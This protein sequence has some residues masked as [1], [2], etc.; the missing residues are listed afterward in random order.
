M[1][2]KLKTHRKK[3]LLFQADKISTEIHRSL[4]LDVDTLHTKYEASTPPSIQ[5]AADTQSRDL[6]KKYIPENCDTKLFESEA[7]E[8]FRG[9]NDK[10]L[11]ANIRFLECHPDGITS[12]KKRGGLNY[13]PSVI[14]SRTSVRNKVL[15]RA[16]ALVHEVLGTL[17]IERVYQACKNGSGSTIGV[18]YVDTSVERKFKFPISATA[19][20]ANL[21]DEYLTWDS[22]LRYALD[23]NEALAAVI[24]PRYK[25]VKGSRATTAEK[26]AT[27]RR[28]ITVGATANMFFQQGLML[29]MYECLRRFNLDVERLPDIHKLLARFSSIHGKQATVDWSQASDS[30]LI[31]LLRFLVPPK[32]FE[33]ID[34]TREPFVEID[35]EFH[36]LQMISTMG[37]A[38]TFPLETLLFWS[39]AVACCSIDDYPDNRLYLE[40]E[41]ILRPDV[42][43]FGDDCILP[44]SS[45]SFFINTLVELG[46][47][48]NIE[49]SYYSEGGG[50]RESCGG[51]YLHGYN[52]RPY[53]LRAP[54][55][56][57]KSAMEPWLYISMNALIP[58]YIQYF[59]A[60]SWCYEK[61]LFKTFERI[62]LEHNLR[63]KIV[64]WNFPAD[65]GLRDNLDL[66]RFLE[67]YPG[68]KQNISRISRSTHGEI[69]FN[70]LSFKYHEKASKRDPDIR[71]ALWLKKPVMPRLPE[72]PVDWSKKRRNGG[73]IVA[74]ALTSF[75]TLPD[76][77]GRR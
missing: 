73:Y 60:L 69:T 40:R 64:P 10:M 19:E 20:A 13:G 17:D 48:V 55:S 53:S 15:L 22:D 18:P 26:N 31:E 21:F 5:R 6:L 49:K 27:T 63:L 46:F 12:R 74:K 14:N 8:R 43:V 59:G 72:L 57:K 32:W 67:N 65:A 62:F 42:S 50:F 3:H 2:R 29:V 61:A 66:R 9:I 39:I 41:Y 58:R 56:L 47:T 34:M 1:T 70:Y 77:L 4:C 68:L 75:W 38:V 37:N 76:V 11:E 54:T 23:V 51:D 28:F 45:A 44:T 52:V 24:Q 30:V 33:W 25:I 35:G 71:Y 7:F 16:R 36:E